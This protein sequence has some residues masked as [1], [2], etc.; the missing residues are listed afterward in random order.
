MQGSSCKNI[1]KKMLWPTIRNGNKIV[2]KNTQIS[3]FL[4]S[5]LDFMS[6]CDMFMLVCC[7]HLLFGFLHPMI[8]ER[9]L[10]VVSS[11][12][13]NRGERIMEHPRNMGTE[14]ICLKLQV[15]SGSYRYPTFWSDWSFVWVG[16]AAQ[17]CDGERV[18]IVCQCGRTVNHVQAQTL[19]TIAVSTRSI[20]NKKEH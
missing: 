4:C 9:M 16:E 10:R 17:I 7:M 15:C 18:R 5:N 8:D 6:R 11:A 3:V 12:A 19:D 1:Q 2:I 13:G 14:K 20:C